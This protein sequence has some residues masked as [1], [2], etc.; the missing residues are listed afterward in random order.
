MA[1]RIS[2][3]ESEQAIQQLAELYPKTFFLD[4]PQ[5]KPLK[6][7]IIADLQRDGAP[8]APELLASAVDSYQT[9]FG[10]QYALQAGAKRVD[11]NG[12]EVGTVT[13]PEHLAARTKII[14][15]RRRLNEKTRPNDAAATMQSLLVQ[16]RIP[17][18]AIRK[19]DAPKEKEMKK[20]YSE[21]IPEQL[22]PVHA[23]LAAAHPDN[24]G[25]RRT[26]F[27]DGRRCPQYSDQG[28][29]ADDR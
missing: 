29:P 16:G 13:E 10:Y 22:A 12:R 26:A 9:H 7:N 18:D 4:P 17:T 21:P 23:A 19:L 24:E 2:R 5:R 6:K 20:D 3:D 11:L 15:D 8:F 14:S 1:I 25:P 27:G 28:S